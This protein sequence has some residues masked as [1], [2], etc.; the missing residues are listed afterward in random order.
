MDQMIEAALSGLAQALAWPAFGYMLVGIAIGFAVGILPGFG[1][2]TGLA[3]MLPFVF[4]MEPVQAFAFLLGMTSV[5]ATTG[6]ITSILFGIPGEATTAATVVD[7]HPMAKRGEAGRALGAVLASSLVG[8]LFGGLL[9]AVAIPIVA[10]LVRTFGSPELF[11]LT[12]LGLTFLASLSGGD[13]KKGLVVAALGLM[14]AMVGRDPQTGTQRFTFGQIHLWDGLGLVAATIGLYA[15]PELIDLAVRGTSIAGSVTT[16]IGGVLQGVKDTF[17]Y[18]QLVLRCSALGAFLGMIPGLGGVVGQW[19]A[20]GHAVQSSP[21][22]ERFGKGAI[23]GV[24]GPGAANNSKEGGNLIPTVAFGVPP[25]VTMA[26]LL[27]AF[28][29]QGLTPGP[30]MLTKHLSITYSMVWIMVIANLI[31]VTACFLFLAQLVR[32]TQIKGSYIIP[33]LLVLIVLGGYTATNQFADVWVMLFFGALGWIMVELDWPRPPLVLGLVLGR[34]AENYLFLSVSRYELGWLLRPG[35]LVGLAIIVV[36]V[37]YPLIA[38][39]LPGY[40]QKLGM[41]DDR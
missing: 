27:G 26:V 12:I 7:G 19:I 2:P 5:T 23:E 39:R 28:I 34:L 1:G 21:D 9:L 18:W 17:H 4:T 25:G 20:Y 29:I 22:R 15:I 30:D 40:W 8:A 6:D 13:V 31:T 16:K 11:V 24:L 3:L 14:L 32:I 10:P 36:A 37:F 33:V 35:V 41:A 38:P